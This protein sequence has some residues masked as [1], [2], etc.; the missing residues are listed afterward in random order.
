MKKLLK[1]ITR[2]SNHHRKGA[3]TVEFIILIPLF[4]LLCLVV[5]QLVII[6]MAVIDTKAALRDAVKV[7][8]TTGDKDKAVKQGRDSFGSSSQ[9]ELSSFKVRIKDGEVYA[10]A[11]TEV[12]ILFMSSSYTYEDTSEAPVLRNDEGFSFI[13]GPPLV[14]GGGLLGPPLRELNITSR[15]GYRTDPVY[16]TRGAFHGGVDFG[17]GMGTPIYAAE[18]GIVVRSGPASGY[19]YVVVI[20]HGNGLLTLYAHMYPHGVFVRAGDRV[21]RGQHI[22]NVGSNGKSTGPHLHFEVHV[23]SYR[24]RVDPLPYLQGG[25]ANR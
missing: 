23:G 16:G 12:P 10:S 18:S 6:S 3:A 1:R 13:V 9:Y 15:F 17:A 4:I 19:G 25:T 20:D 8:S 5:W 21:E 22:A 2:Y 24:N 14:G 11:K 7:G